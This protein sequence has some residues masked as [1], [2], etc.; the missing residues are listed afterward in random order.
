MTGN[1]DF[2]TEFTEDTFYVDADVDFNW[3]ITLNSPIIGEWTANGELIGDATV[4]ANWPNNEV[5]VTLNDF[6]SFNLLEVIHDT[7]S[8]KLTDIYLEPGSVTF[9]W[10]RDDV[11]Q[12]GWILIDSEFTQNLCS[13]NLAELT[14]GTKSISVGWP[15][16][17]PGDFKFTWDVPNKIMTVNNGIEGLGPTV[18]YKDTSQNREIFASAGNL[19]DDYSKTMSL[20]WYEDGGQ[21]SGL[22]LDTDDAYLANLVSVGSIKG[23]SDGKKISLD[24]LKC[25]DFYIRKLSGEFQIGGSLQLASGITFSKLENNDWKDLSVE[26]DLT[27]QE[28]MI[29]FERDPDFDLELKLFSV[30]ILGFTISSE[31]N[32]LYGEFCEIRWDIGDQGIV[33]IDTDNEYVASISFTI[34]PD[35]G[36]GLDITIYTLS[37]QDW[38]VAWDL[39]PPEDLYVYTGGTINFGSIDIDV[40]YD[41]EWH[42]LWP[43]S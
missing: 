17:K 18:T 21:I 30:D 14:W 8:F 15:C 16:L 34:G 25:N 9:S 42:D 43:L 33:R 4:N 1:G 12:N 22:K 36:I 3:E 27:S 7:L 38:W 2:T 29:R 13:V 40:Y 37:A 5:A 35:Y 24:G 10:Y 6:G 23:A 11:N 20:E 31:I 39:W 41:G 28:K 19:Q 26:W 32:L